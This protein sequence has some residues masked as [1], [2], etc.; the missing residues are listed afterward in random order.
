MWQEHVLP[1]TKRYERWRNM[2]E[3]QPQD[4]ATFLKQ[5][6][7]PHLKEIDLSL[8]RM[9]RVMEALGHPENMLPP[10][11][12]I[13]GTNGKG[14]LSAYLRAMFTAAGKKAHVYTSPHLVR[15]HERF[16]VAGQEVQQTLLTHAL[17][18]VSTLKEVY[19]TTFFEGITAAGFLLFSETPADVLILEVGLGG[20]L[21]STNVIP[22]PA[23]SVI[24]P[25]SLDHTEFLGETLAE[26]AQE[27]SG[28]IKEG[29]PCVVGPQAPEALA[30]IEQY[31]AHL[32]APLFRYGKEWK[33]EEGY[34]ISQQHRIPL[35]K[36]GLHGP[37]QWKNA[38]T[39]IAC[40][41]ALNFF[42]RVVSPIPIAAQLEGIQKVVWPGRLQPLTEAHWL[43]QLPEGSHLWL[44]G[45][46]N[47]A[48]GKA[49]AD[50]VQAERGAEAKIHLICGML[51]N[52]DA[53]GFLQSL[54]P[55]I[56]HAWMI[57]IPHEPKSAL[58]EKLV[59]QAKTIGASA[60]AC[61]NLAAALAEITQK[62]KAVQVVIAGSLYLAGA[63]LS[64]TV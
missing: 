2:A 53:V 14:S 22:A 20:R 39:A 12:H 57:P 41:D 60:T 7:N 10:I 3:L 40:M 55:Y 50:W 19:P 24:T 45:G 5:M 4:L 28:I 15:F 62:G 30:V 54:A 18:R 36:P 42:R 61:T 23:L 64:E 52:K 26:I 46:H 32:Q 58:P 38:A 63:V 9:E 17:Q 6:E 21:D 47:P 34:Y 59:A 37:H 29:S 27:K 48:G 51:G 8:G 49:I 31:A 16:I 56:E 33:L 25:V 43:R 35:P 44:D 13:A 1:F 11:I